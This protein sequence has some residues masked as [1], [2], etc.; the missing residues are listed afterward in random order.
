MT[1]T[2]G[3][4]VREGSATKRT[5]ILVAARD[6]FLADGYERTSVD[7]VSA[8]AGVSKRTV[9]DYF[10]D[11]RALLLAV[12]EQSGE[13][14][15][16]TVRAAI[17][18]ELLLERDLEASLTAFTTRIVST[19]GSAEYAA[20]IRLV[21]AE[22]AHLPALGEH[23][24]AHAPEDAVAERL[25]ELGRRGLLE[26]PDPRLAA[27]HLIALT[28]G[29]VQNRMELPSPDAPGVER[30]LVEGVRAFLRAYE[31]RD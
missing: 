29:M 15:M 16:R 30:L 10:G 17:D 24:L 8:K 26:V 20:V 27:D 4:G 28:F 11:K 18:E 6:L 23:W 22:A 19:V 9:Y 7:A 14:L 5:A 21:V 13:A 1:A 25:A 3:K 31:P 12:V 2:A